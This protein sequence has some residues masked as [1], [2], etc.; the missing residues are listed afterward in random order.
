MKYFVPAL[1]AL[2]LVI[3]L[4]VYLPS[5]MPTCPL[6]KEPKKLSTEEI[7]GLPLMS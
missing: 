7:K 3:I 4:L 2:L 5:V 6:S 1:F